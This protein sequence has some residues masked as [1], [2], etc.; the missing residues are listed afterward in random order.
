MQG[1]IQLCLQHRDHFEPFDTY[2]SNGEQQID[3]S[4][5]QQHQQ[6]LPVHQLLD[7]IDDNDTIPVVDDDD[8]DE[9]EEYIVDRLLRYVGFKNG[10][11]STHT[12]THAQM[13]AAVT[14]AVKLTR[15]ELHQVQQLFQVDILKWSD[16]DNIKATRRQ[17]KSIIDMDDDTNVVFTAL[18]ERENGRTISV[19]K[20]NNTIL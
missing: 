9:K 12:V 15:A 14:T 2:Q 1:G 8:S 4:H 5:A 19:W 6:Q 7:N 16:P 3:W 18:Q 11:R 13:Q 10:R 17:L 20:L